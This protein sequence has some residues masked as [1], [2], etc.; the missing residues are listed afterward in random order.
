MRDRPTGA[1][2]LDTARQVLRD[3]LI[4]ALP[5]DKRMSAL[6][7]ANALA[8]AARQLQNGDDLERAELAALEHLL[9][10]PFAPASGDT[11]AVR[12]G[13]LS[14]NRKLSEWI[15]GGRAD[16]GPLREDVRAHLASAIRHKVAESNP[17]YLGPQG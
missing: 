17:K 5:A 8:I 11:A 7:I 3:E 12:G 13:L 6:M 4:P 16:D 15:R 9:S 1:E 2:L 10:E 14:A